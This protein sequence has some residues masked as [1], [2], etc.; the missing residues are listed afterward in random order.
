MWLCENHPIGVHQVLD[1]QVY[2]V[3]VPLDGFAACDCDGFHEA[4]QKLKSKAEERQVT[5]RHIAMVFGAHCGWRD[6][7][8]HTRC[9]SCGKRMI[10]VEDVVPGWVGQDRKSLL[11]DL[12]QLRKELHEED[13]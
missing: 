1:G 4:K 5:C 10:H 11:N 8:G 2:V 7:H 6:A 13:G 9:V 3:T 12:L